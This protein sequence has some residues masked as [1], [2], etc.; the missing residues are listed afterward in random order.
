MLF[1]P[2]NC[3]GSEHVTNRKV[4]PGYRVVRDRLWYA[5]VEVLHVA[6]CQGMCISQRWRFQQNLQVDII[7]AKVIIAQ[8]G[9]HLGILGR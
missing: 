9:E 4:A 8:V 7:R 2:R 3:S 1:G 5:E 6:Y